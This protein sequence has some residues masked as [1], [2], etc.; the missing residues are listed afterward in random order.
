MSDAE[1]LFDVRVTAGFNIRLDAIERFYADAGAPASA[2]SLLLA[3]HDTVIPNLARFPRMG[4]PYGRHA[5]QSVEARSARDTLPEG[6]ME[7]LREY[8]HDDFLILYSVSS[9]ARQVHLLSI[10][11]HRELSFDFPGLWQ[12]G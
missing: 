8:L 9:G 3:L 4:R 10:R 1:P 7:T 11:H 6:Q 5:L 12:G 2:Q